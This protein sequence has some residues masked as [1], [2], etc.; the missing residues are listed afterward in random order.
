M[1]GSKKLPQIDVYMK[2]ARVGTVTFEQPRLCQFEYT[3]SWIADGFPISPCFPLTGEIKPQ[4]VS[5]FIKNLFPEGS[6]FDV[7]LVTENLSQNNLYAILK[8][9]GWDTAGAL[10]F[11][12]AGLSPKNPPTSLRQ[13]TKDELA[14]RL[15]SHSDLTV[16]DGKFRLSVAGVQDKLNVYVDSNQ[17]IFLADGKYASTHILK[18][19]SPRF[20]TVV[21]NELF[22]MRLA[23]TVGLKTANVEHKKLGDHSA[24][25]V[26][27]FDRRPHPTGVDKHH[28]ID[29]CQALDL[30]PE[31]K[32]EQSFGNSK[33]VAH[34]REGA[35]LKKL[36]GFA[37]HCEVPAL[38]IETLIDWMLF[39]LIIGNS[40]AHGKNFSFF[41]RRSGITPT[42]FYDLISIVFEATQQKNL[43]THLA[44]AIG[45]NFDALSITAF[46]LLTLADEAEIKFDLLQ[47]RLL[48]LTA[49]CSSLVSTL[50]FSADE[51]SEEQLETITSLSQLVKER[52]DNLASQG[53][54]FNS[55]IES[56]F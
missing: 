48:K 35:S 20:P 26:K 17:A 3:D 14:R 10:R 36:F 23:A 39:N 27:R 8:R 49:A 29:G 31:H 51:L 12:E 56:A 53:R 19:S 46:D 38:T 45:D 50:D 6:A 54:L 21:I 22:C 13:I 40:D 15:D 47:R 25:L 5:N 44:M 42:P 28:M 30:P 9:I 11:S 52:S 37:Q 33:D 1:A 16:W 43:D 32:Y 34:I 41:I 7:L 24:L 4:T 18:F 2:E 55:V